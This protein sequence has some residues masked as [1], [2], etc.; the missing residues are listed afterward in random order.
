MKLLNKT[1]CIV[2]LFAISEISAKVTKKPAEAP[3]RVI[4]PAQPATKPAAQPIVP[5]TTYKQL[6][7]QVRSIQSTADVINPQTKLLHNRFVE[8]MK[9]TVKNMQ[10]ASNLQKQGLET[11]LQTARD[12]FFPFGPDDNQNTLYLEKINEQIHDAVNAL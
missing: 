11:L 12:M 3:A 2:A 8:N 6:Y 7:D 9:N 5:T 1:I 10:V 4:L